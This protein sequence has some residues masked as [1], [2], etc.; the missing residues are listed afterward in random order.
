MLA[1]QGQSA[2]KLRSMR[3]SQ[4]GVASFARSPL[5]RTKKMN[6]TVHGRNSFIEASPLPLTAEPKKSASQAKYQ[7]QR[8]GWNDS[9]QLVE[10]V[11]TEPSECHEPVAASNPPELRRVQISDEKPIVLK[12]DTF[13]KM[14]QKLGNLQ[15]QK[16][17]SSESKPQLDAPVEATKEEGEAAKQGSTPGPVASEQTASSS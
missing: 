12:K 1:K 8:R 9:H 13:K 11:H 3:A 6:A 4:T 17:A 15:I 2:A 14:K 16:Q 7:S 10:A 5:D